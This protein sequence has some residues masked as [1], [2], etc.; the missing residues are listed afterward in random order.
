MPARTNWMGGE[1]GEAVKG[2]CT[3][4]IVQRDVDIKMNKNTYIIYK[5]DKILLTFTSKSKVLKSICKNIIKCEEK[6]D[7]CQKC[8]CPTAETQV[9]QTTA[10]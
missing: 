3:T 9:A 6:G 10:M 1:M 7:D 4:G 2:K 8:K 5:N